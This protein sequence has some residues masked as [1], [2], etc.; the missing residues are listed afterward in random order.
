[1]RDVSIIRAA[2]RG[3]SVSAIVQEFLSTQGN[4]ERDFERRKRLQD[5]VLAS[6]RNFQAADRMTRTEVH[7]R[8][9]SR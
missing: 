7:E 2:E 9:V 8:T 3:T 5:E 6:V 4:Q 1:M